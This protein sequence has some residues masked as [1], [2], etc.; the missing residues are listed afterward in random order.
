[1]S[2]IFY[3]I[4]TNKSEMLVTEPRTGTFTIPSVAN[5]RTIKEMKPIDKEEIDL[6]FRQYVRANI[7]DKIEISGK[8]TKCENEGKNIMVLVHAVKDSDITEFTK[9]GYTFQKTFQYKKDGAKETTEKEPI[10]LDTKSLELFTDADYKTKDSPLDKCISSALSKTT[11]SGIKLR[12]SPKE[13]LYL[14]F[15]RPSLFIPPFFIDPVASLFAQQR[16]GIRSP[17]ASPYTSPYSSP[18]LSPRLPP[19]F[20]SMPSRVRLTPGDAPR[21]ARSPRV[22]RR[23]DME[24]GY[25][26]KYVKYKGKYLA[27]KKQGV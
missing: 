4:I 20:D 1:M 2:T 16:Y 15:F 19:S 24:G 5:S 13:K 3:L 8:I 9:N 12:G 27:L 23:I 10:S 22:H 17:Y 25:Y 21:V 11:S 7:N 18:R 14:T 6:Q 26:E